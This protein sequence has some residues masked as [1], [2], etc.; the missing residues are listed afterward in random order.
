MKAADVMKMPAMSNH[1]LL[2]AIAAMVFRV[3][4][5]FTGKAG[6]RRRKAT[7]AISARS[8]HNF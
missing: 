3:L 6:L 7:S 1:G 5:F 4:H 2:T 8:A